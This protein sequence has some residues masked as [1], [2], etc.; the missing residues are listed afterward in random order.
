MRR[1][2][3]VTLVLGLGAG[4]MSGAV[5]RA[6][7]AATPVTIKNFAYSP[8]PVTVT[9]GT[10]ITWTN[11]DTAPHTAT[12][13]SPGFDTGMLQTGQSGSV[14][15]NQVGTFAYHCSVHPNMH[16]TVIVQASV[17][18][19]GSPVGL[20]SYH[21]GLANQSSGLS[22]MG[23]AAGKQTPYLVTDVSNRAQASSMRANFAPALTRSSGLSR[24]YLVAGRAAPD[25]LAV[26]AAGPGV[27]GYSPLRQE[28]LVRW[29]SGAAV[30]LLTGEGQIKS[31]LKQGKLTVRST[32]IVVNAPAVASGT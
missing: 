18:L 7:A 20:P 25:Q 6:S 1:I 4:L 26:L 17:P 28:L 22:W 21:I 19:S 8:N 14:T 5:P 3:K 2:G 16:G 23:Y 32:G 12:S 31:L 9:V 29:K 27:A 24:M 15:F 30:H 11:Q 13:D 10:Q